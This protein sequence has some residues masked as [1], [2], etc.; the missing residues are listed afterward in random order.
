MNEILTP[1]QWVELQGRIRKQ[2]PELRDEDMLY[3]EAA[4]QDML[5][6]VA[7]CIRKAKKELRGKVVK[8]YRISTLKNNWNYSRKIRIVQ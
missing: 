6:M 5:S 1:D 2:H 8:F 4:E 3:H 7:C